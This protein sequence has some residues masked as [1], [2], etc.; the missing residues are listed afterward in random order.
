[1]GFFKK[2]IKFVGGAVKKVVPSAI[3]A[4][5]G[6]DVK[7]IFGKSESNATQGVKDYEKPSVVAYGVKNG[8]VTAY[9]IN[10]ER[11]AARSSGMSTGWIIAGA[12]LV[13]GLFGGRKLLR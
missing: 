12:A 9:D 3:K 10:Q 1:M 2:A 11:A 13:L 7:G 5:T 4:V 8:E 6:V